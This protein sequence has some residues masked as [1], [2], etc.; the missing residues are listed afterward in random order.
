MA[1]RPSMQEFQRLAAARE[2][3]SASWGLL[4]MSSP[5]PGGPSLASGDRIR[6]VERPGEP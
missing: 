6:R 3:Y 2:L 5:H 4:Q 1:S